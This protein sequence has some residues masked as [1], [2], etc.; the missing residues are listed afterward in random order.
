MVVGGLGEGFEFRLLVAVL[1]VVRHRPRLDFGV[2][3]HA[4]HE[5]GR[6]VGLAGGLEYG[7]V[8][9]RTPDLGA[10]GGAF[11]LHDAEYD[12][13]LVAEIEGVSGLESGLAEVGAERAGRPVAD[14]AG[15]LLAARFLMVAVLGEPLAP[16]MQFHV[17]NRGPDGRALE[18]SQ[19]EEPPTS[20]LALGHRHGLIHHEVGLEA[21]EP[22]R[23]LRFLLL[24]HVRG[25][26]REPAIEADRPTSHLVRRLQTA[27]LL[28]LGEF[29][30][31]DVTDVAVAEVAEEFVGRAVGQHHH[32]AG[33]ARA[34]VQL[35]HA[36]DECEQHH[37]ERDDHGEGEGREGGVALADPQIAEVVSERHFADEHEK[38]QIGG[39]NEEEHEGPVLHQGRR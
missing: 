22:H 12:P 14:H 30:L 34:F 6:A 36:V 5:R 20:L 24:G 9:G 23:A 25:E 7:V 16:R 18:R 29:D 31:L 10:E 8:E 19:L 11:G 13:F 38:E 21:R 32:V 2:I 17:V 15:D 4:Q 27:A 26:R 3:R 1:E 28:I 37:D 35:V 33:N 39:V